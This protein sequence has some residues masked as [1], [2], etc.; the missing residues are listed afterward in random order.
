V[1]GRP[2]DVPEF[3]RQKAI[4][5]GAAGLRW[6]EELPA[7]V[8]QLESEWDVVVGR[9]LTGG[10]ESY[11]AWATLRDGTDAVIRLQLP[12]DPAYDT[13]ASFE[14]TA[15]IFGA[16]NG[17]A[18]A[19]LLRSDPERRALLLERL[20][21]S[22]QS[23]GLPR[24]VQLEVLCELLR[25][26]WRVEPTIELGS[27]SEKARRLAS[28]I[29]LTWEELGRP[30]SERAVEMALG[31]AESRA[32]EFDP[33]ASVVVHGD[34]HP[35]NALGTLRSAADPQRSF[36]FVDPECFL[37][38]PAYDLGVCMRDWSTEL[39]AGDDAADD[40]HELCVALALLSGVPRQPIWEWAFV[41]RVSTGLFALQVRAELMGRDLLAVADLIARSTDQ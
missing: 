20:G 15:W 18:Y 34:A 36:K 8:A 32:R 28:F 39:L 41:E 6:F 14:T 1:D 19:R 37:A 38:E 16:A 12:R 29:R 21:P 10:S 2:L 22:L 9:P 23:S 26:A 5:R 25:R 3:V 30:C 13:D 24:S 11:V 40:A 27:G 17:S 4:Q 35:G 33:E 7:L 31:F